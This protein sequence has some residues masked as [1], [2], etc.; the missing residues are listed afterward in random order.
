[1]EKIFGF[2][3]MFAIVGATYLL[4]NNKK[5]I[6][7]KSVGCA[8]IGQIILALLLIKTPLW[9]GVEWV[10]NGTLWLLG[11]ANEGITFVFGDLAGS[12]F[13]LFFNALLP[14]VFVSSLMGLLFHFGILQKF[15]AVV[16]NTV[17]KVLK[18]DTLVAVN[19]ISNMFL[20]QSDSLFITKSYLSSPKVND[21]VIFATLCG[22]MTSISASVVGLYVGYGASMEW[23]IVSMPLTVFSTFVLTQ[24]LMPTK[25]DAETVVEV[26]PSKTQPPK[27]KNWQK[28]QADNFPKWQFSW[29][30]GT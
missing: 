27:F 12:G 26:E 19:G 1:M 24:I 17:A 25:F 20:G 6:N 10:A 8:F 2:V 3:G 16:G 30:T 11:Q 28:N 18:V 23:I 13:C 15:I 21:S 29:P 5:G 14:I 7:W 4:S 9:K 22:G